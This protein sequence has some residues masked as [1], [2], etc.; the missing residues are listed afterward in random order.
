MEALRGPEFSD[1]TFRYIND[2][3]DL[4]LAAVDLPNTINMDDVRDASE[5][6]AQAPHLALKSSLQYFMAQSPEIRFTAKSVNAVFS[7]MKM[8]PESQPLGQLTIAILNNLRDNSTDD[9]QWLSPELLP[10][11]METAQVQMSRASSFG[12]LDANSMYANMQALT[13]P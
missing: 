12:I 2:I 13:N 9:T 1:A 6:V 10:T 11:L 8:L 5:A 3:R 4:Q 7:L